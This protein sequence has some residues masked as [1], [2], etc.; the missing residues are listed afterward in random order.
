MAVAILWR[1]RG[2]KDLLCFRHQGFVM[3]FVQRMMTVD[4]IFPWE[5]TARFSVVDQCSTSLF[6]R[7][8]S[9]FYSKKCSITCYT[10][11]IVT[12]HRQREL[13]SL[14]LCHYPHESASRK[15][16][17][18][19][20]KGQQ[21]AARPG[22]ISG[23]ALRSLRVARPRPRCPPRVVGAPAR[24]WSPLR[25]FSVP[26]VRNNPPHHRRAARLAGMVC[27]HGWAH[28]LDCTGERG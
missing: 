23:D 22:R 18:E 14:S 24:R 3:I 27:A 6:L 11:S 21:R 25:P 15:Y 5:I 10:S 2:N 20:R 1:R 19:R 17:S 16:T 4:E 26:A 9:R 28:G 13:S 8:Y 7:F 12:Q